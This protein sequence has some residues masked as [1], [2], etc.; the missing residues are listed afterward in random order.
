MGDAGKFRKS[1]ATVGGIPT[2]PQIIEMIITTW[3][4]RGL[5]NKEK[6]RYLKERLKKYKPNIMLIQE[7]KIR[8]HKLKEVI[9]NFKP[10]YEIIGQDVVGSVGGVAILWNLEEVQFEDWISIPQILSRR[11]RNIGSQE[12]ILLSNV[13]GPNIL[14]ERRNFF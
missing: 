1:G 6:Q 14:S 7:T 2:T 5:N 12:W 9:S 4:I 11:F 13:Y 3:N 10:H 8:E